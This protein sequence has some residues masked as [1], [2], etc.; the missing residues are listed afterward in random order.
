MSTTEIEYTQEIPDGC[1]DPYVQMWL[2]Q[3]PEDYHNEVLALLLNPSVDGS[4]AT[5]NGSLVGFGLLSG[6]KED[7]IM[8]D[9]FFILSTQVAVT[10]GNDNARERFI[11]FMSRICPKHEKTSFIDCYNTF[12]FP[13]RTDMYMVTNL[14]HPDYRGRGI[15]TELLERRLV[16]AEEKGATGVFAHCNSDASLHLY[17]KRGFTSIMQSGPLHYDGT[18]DVLVAKEF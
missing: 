1:V 6:L 17:E 3:W 12:R 18:A 2:K 9:L 5:Y 7:D 4:V 13:T 10:R 8:D 11:D 16:M 15:G 14:V